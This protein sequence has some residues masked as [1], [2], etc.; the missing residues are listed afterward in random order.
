M[1]PKDDA[2]VENAEEIGLIASDP[3]E[4]KLLEAFTRYQTDFRERALAKRARRV[5]V[6]NVKKTQ[7]KHVSA[8]CQG[9]LAGV[10]SYVK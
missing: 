7:G 2:E 6:G 5:Q 10:C 4:E 3:S 1:A 9:C 8:L